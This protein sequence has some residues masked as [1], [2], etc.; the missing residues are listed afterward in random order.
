MG[1]VY[2]ALDTRLKRNV[3]IKILSPKLDADSDA[4]RRFEQEARAASA[5][6]HPAIVTV[7]DAGT[8]NGQTFLVTELLEGTTLR[9]RL[10]KGP[11][12]V[13]DVL[14]VAIQVAGGLGAAHAAGIVHRDIKPE[15]IF[16]TR[17]GAVKILDFGI[18]RLMA[19]NEGERGAAS[20]VAATSAGSVIGTAGYMAP[21]QVRG[22]AIDARADI[23]AFGCVLYE[24]LSGVRAFRKDTP[25]DTLASI[26]TEE[27]PELHASTAIP[28]PLV[29]ILRRCLRKDPADRFQSALDL[30][31]AL[32]AARDDGTPS[33]ARGAIRRGPVS[34]VLR[35]IPIAVL[36]GAAIAAALWITRNPEPLSPMSIDAVSVVPSSAKPIAPALSPDGKW[37]AYISVGETQPQAF[38]QFLNGGLP[39]SLTRGSDIPVQNRTIVGGID[40]SPDGSS[41][42]LAGR[43]TLMGLYQ[44]PGIWILPAPLGGPARKVT[45][46]YASFKWSPDGRRLAAVVANPL[47]GDAIVVAAIDGQDERMVVPSGGGLHLHQVA[48]SH[49]GRHVYYAQSFEAT[50]T[51]SEIYRAPVGGGRPE[52]VV[53]T[54]GVARNPAPTPDGRALVY[55]GDHAGEGLNIWWHPLDG[56]PQRRLTA[57]AGEYT[58]PYISRDGRSLVCLA[59]RRKGELI[60][61]AVDEKSDPAPVALGL[62]GSGDSDPSTSLATDRLFISSPRNGRRK[63]WSIDPS[64]GQAIPLTTGDWVDQRPV[65]SPDGRSVAFISNRGG[66][67][68]IW[69]V[70][71]D[72]GTPRLLVHGDVLDRV[73]WSPDSRHLV[74]SSAGATVT[75]LWVVQAGGGTPR[76]IPGASGRTPAWSPT[77]DVIAAVRSDNNMPVV[78]LTSSTG[79]KVREPLAIKSVGLPTALA[80]SPEG[81]R[82]VLVNLPGMAAAEAWVITVADGGMRKLLEL[83]APA[84]LDG[85]AWTRDGRYIIAGRTEYETEVLLISGLPGAGR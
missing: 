45:D 40:I 66:R 6:N 73:S 18:A 22:G 8:E 20:T 76:Q 35:W 23:F 30:A 36:T 70:P 77:G 21:E 78:H 47:I 74:Y 48:W 49:D 41:I 61:V 67:R 56:S 17:R 68:G 63:V 51:L 28:T 1:E 58:E 59:R 16:L 62:E 33:A 75:S 44:I 80:W 2:R 65:V 53:Q 83:P 29:R 27:P 10:E 85:I 79:A 64:G 13:G 32:T 26:V 43:A 60:R 71:A 37:V 57:G 7:F 11:L 4:V 3:A 31:F 14:D 39:M 12:P 5:L 69:I 84:E 9:A 81:Q 72:G 15:N 55:A 82:L 25:F 24:M 38:V 19:E 34:H 46:R 42:A 52:P 50:H 54:A